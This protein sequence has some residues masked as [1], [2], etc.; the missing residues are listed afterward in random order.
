MI[1][2]MNDFMFVLYISCE[3]FITRIV[4]LHFIVAAVVHLCMAGSS[5]SNSFTC[6]SLSITTVQ[7]VVRSLAHLASHAAGFMFC[8]CYFLLS[9]SS[10][11]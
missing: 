7:K 3:A 2:L 4:D 10:S 9:S 5:L 11:F 8:R 6:R 1:T